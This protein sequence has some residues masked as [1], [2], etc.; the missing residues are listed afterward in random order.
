MV[1]MIFKYSTGDEVVNVPTEWNDITFKQYVEL[2]KL[3]N[4]PDLLFEDRIKNRFKA[5]LGVTTENFALLKITT[6]EAITSLLLFSFDF[7]KLNEFYKVPE[8]FKNFD[9][10]DQEWQ[11]LIECQ[12]AMKPIYVSYPITPEMSAEEKEEVGIKILMEMYEVGDIFVKAFTGKD[13]KNEKLTDVYW[14][15]AFFLTK[16]YNFFLSSEMMMGMMQES[17]VISTND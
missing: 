1:E 6:V 14:M 12:I 9:V 11:K 5:F 17:S 13:I 10:G 7:A 4:E 3:E 15:P 2:L 8:E 16:Y